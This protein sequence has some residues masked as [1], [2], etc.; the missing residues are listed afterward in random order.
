MISFQHWRK[1]TS[2]SRMLVRLRQKPVRPESALS[3]SV[4]PQWVQPEE[5]NPESGDFFWWEKPTSNMRDGTN[6]PKT[7]LTGYQVSIIN[8]NM[9]AI[10]S[11]GRQMK[12]FSD[13]PR[14]YT[15]AR[16]P[17]VET[18]PSWSQMIFNGVQPSMGVRGRPLVNARQISHRDQT[19]TRNEEDTLQGDHMM[20]HSSSLPFLGFW[21]ISNSHLIQ[22]QSLE[23]RWNLQ[24]Q[25]IRCRRI[26]TSWSP[27]FVHTRTVGN[28]IQSLP[29]C[30]STSADTLERSPTNAMQTDAR[31]ASP[32]W[33][34][35]TDTREST[36]GR[37]PTCVLRATGTLP[38]LIT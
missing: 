19:E 13:D 37:G 5:A 27:I 35:S 22:G 1:L 36:L 6:I 31:G 15:V 4:S 29:T 2:S 18:R 16:W 9:M 26:L 14:S 17:S 3:T 7:S 23:Q 33:M 20:P 11:E 8:P 30:E 21:C 34:S 25:S 28:H 38:H 12:T 32:I 24:I 10:P